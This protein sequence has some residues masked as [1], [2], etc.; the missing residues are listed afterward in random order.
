MSI[1]LTLDSFGWIYHSVFP[2]N[3]NQYMWSAEQF[4]TFI[5]LELYY[6]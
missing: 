1:V 3:L 6:K 2:L 5:S 4:D